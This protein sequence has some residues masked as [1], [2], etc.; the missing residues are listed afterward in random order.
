[1][2]S[3]A[4]NLSVILGSFL[5][6]ILVYILVFF[7]RFL[8]KINV[9]D[10][11]KDAA[12]I[13]YQQ[14][15]FYV[16][17]SIFA[18][19]LVNFSIRTISS[20][21]FFEINIFY[22]Q[23]VLALLYITAIF[24]N[25][26]LLLDK[27]GFFPLITFIYAAIALPL[28]FFWLK[29]NIFE[30]FHPL[31]PNYLLVKLCKGLWIF[32]GIIFCLASSFLRKRKES[33]EIYREYY[34]GVN[35]LYIYYLLSQIISMF[36][37]STILDYGFAAELLF[38]IPNLFLMFILTETDFVSIQHYKKPYLYLKQRIIF[39][40]IISLAVIIIISLELVN[41]ATIFIVKAELVSAKKA[42]FFNISSQLKKDIINYYDDKKQELWGYINKTS[43]SHSFYY[44][45]ISLFNDLQ[46]IK[47][48]KKVLI[49]NARGEPTL[50]ISD[51][52]LNFSYSSEKSEQYAPYIEECRA[53]GFRY[54]FD[55]TNKNLELT[56][57]QFQVNKGII[58][59]N[60]F[61]KEND[62]SESMS[63]EI[64]EELK[65]NG[66][67]NNQGLLTEAF[68]PTDIQFKLPLQPKY[69]KYM[70][71]VLG[72]LRPI[73][74]FVIAFYEPANLYQLVKNYSFERNGEI[75]L[76]NSDYSLIYSSYFVDSFKEELNKGKYLEIQDKL[77]ITSMIIVVKQP[78][79][80][81]F[82]GLQKAQYNSFFF[83]TLAIV[84][85]LLIAFLF[86]RII[87]KPL[88][89]LQ[90]GAKIIGKGDL[91]HEILIKEKNEFYE[92]AI[93]F[94]NMVNDLKKLQ[95]EQLKKEQILSITQ[96]SVGLNHEINNPVATIM[97]GSQLVLKLFEKIDLSNEQE[98]RSKME[99]IQNTAKQIHEESRRVAKIIKDIQHIN[100]PIIE[101][102]VDGIK[103]VKV[104]FD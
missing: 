58:S 68:K 77:P 38:S 57:L 2:L 19:T 20:I 94:N 66:I 72:I 59:K 51:N 31:I 64:W 27:K 100:E 23:G 15:L 9:Q 3:F 84:T 71:Y 54:S 21:T 34:F 45:G 22:L 89:A 101:D 26:N 95:K 35:K 46:K 7:F 25:L 82:T 97:M 36:F 24:V 1:M 65:K 63:S 14:N 73:T 4:F 50:E 43:E 96:L 56:L 8:R 62:I 32:T 37:T 29:T 30:G 93:A 87:E 49:F 61:I 104:K 52:N 92:L 83:T 75:Q 81:A 79:A 67:I 5:L 28:T 13:Q 85:F 102:Y 11:D 78:E 6:F 42:A 33:N 10:K 40:M 80:D 17:I 39:R 44:L 12:L 91:N 47:G 18:I 99:V 103:M 48:L 98:L 55:Q 70:Q 76:Y 60:A 74:G 41:Y 53:K 69:E 90:E 16:F 86:L 88:R